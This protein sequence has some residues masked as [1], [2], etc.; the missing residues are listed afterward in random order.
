MEQIKIN[1]LLAGGSKIQ[2]IC[3]KLIFALTLNYVFDLIHSI[4]VQFFIYQ[5]ICHILENI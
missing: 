3:C 2:Q 1:P 5:K 4:N